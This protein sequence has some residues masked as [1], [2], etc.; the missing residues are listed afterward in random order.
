MNDATM[1]S[2]DT[3]E[4]FIHLMNDEDY[5][6]IVMMAQELGATQFEGSIRTLIQEGPIDVDPDRVDYRALQEDV[7]N[8]D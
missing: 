2:W 4:T 1:N 5:A 8:M 7:Y 6:R 3:E